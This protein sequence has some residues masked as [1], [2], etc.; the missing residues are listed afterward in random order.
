MHKAQNLNYASD[1]LFLKSDL[2]YLQNGQ[3]NDFWEMSVG[4][5]R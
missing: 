4:Q 3:T 2:K 5:D 1:A